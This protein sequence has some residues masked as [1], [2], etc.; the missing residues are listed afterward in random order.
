MTTLEAPKEAKKA[1]EKGLGLAKKGKPDEALREISK[2]VEVYPRYAAAWFD[3]GRL[4][5]QSRKDEDA[6]KAYEAAVRADAKYVPPY[7]QLAGIAV[8]EQKWQEAADTS[9]RVLRLNPFDYPTIYLF[10][11][12]ANYNLQ[13]MD[14]AEKAAREGIKQDE[15]RRTPK[16][17]HI[18]GVILAQKEDY[19]S[20]A[21]QMKA[22]LKFA[23]NAGDAGM[24]QNQLAEIE[25]LAANNPPAGTPAKP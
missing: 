7:L 16:L 18:L 19:N 24:V 2:A 15:Q 14:A 4:H 8:R 25:K 23:P 17:L 3:L 5:E 13:K 12:V 1:Y 20:A 9:D 22:Y 10:S 11:A 6:R 21:E